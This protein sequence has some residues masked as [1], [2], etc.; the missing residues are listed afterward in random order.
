MRNQIVP[1]AIALALLAGC[2]TTKMSGEQLERVAKD[3][4]MSIR[5]SQVIP[6]YPL[7]EDLQPGDVFLVQ[8]PVEDQV[9]LYQEKGFLPLENLI[10][11]LPVEGYDTFYRGWPGVADGEEAPP[12]LWQFPSS[13]SAAAEFAQ[14]PLAKFPSYS[15]AV[16]RSTGL[17]VAIPVQGVPLGLNLLDSGSAN[18]TITMKDSYTY[19]LPARI[20]FSSLIDW[21]TKNAAY[22]QQFAP[23]RTVPGGKPAQPFFLRVVNR[24][25]LVKTVD[26][27]LFDNRA[28][29][30][31]GSAGVPRTVELLNIANATDAAKRFEQVNQ[32]ISKATQPPGSEQPAV[33]AEGAAADAAKGAPLAGG[34]VKVAMATNRSISLVESFARPLVIGYLAF[35]FPIL[36]G[37]AMGAPVATF[38]QLENRPQLT[39]QP[40]QY[41]GC[42]QQ[43]EALRAWRR[44]SPGNV[45]RLKSWLAANGGISISNF[46]TGCNAGLR[47]RAV[48]ELIDQ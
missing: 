48:Q 28:T 35:D 9:K 46:E 47:Q 23:P 4:S 30:A 18:G 13:G 17:N 21:S 38:A 14:A 10:V 19:G 36:D 37:G 3:W 15:F 27:S 1:A 34:T 42:D 24:V 32:I 43:C 33:T 39:G 20:L 12:R 8:T 22:L 40:I 2:S 5:A 11:R 29:G 41:C 16:S 26:V 45:D 6:V 44:A 7:T 31:T 25:Y